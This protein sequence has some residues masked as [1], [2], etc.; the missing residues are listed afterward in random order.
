[1][2]EYGFFLLFIEV[3]FATLIVKIVGNVVFR[4]IMTG[5]AG[6]VISDGGS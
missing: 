1:M 6:T 2:D 3:L 4:I 5:C